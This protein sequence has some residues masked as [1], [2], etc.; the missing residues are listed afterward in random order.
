MP[1]RG[2]RDALRQAEL[3]AHEVE[4]IFR[5]GA[6]DDGKG[7][8]EPD[9]PAWSRNRRHLRLKARASE[10]PEFR[11]GIPYRLSLG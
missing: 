11:A 5:I 9:R 4:E 1:W 8:V 10:S 3:A 2:K 6:V 7:R